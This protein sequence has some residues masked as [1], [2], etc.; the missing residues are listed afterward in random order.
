LWGAGQ[1][2]SEWVCGLWVEHN[3]NRTEEGRHKLMAVTSVLIRGNL[4]GMRPWGL[5]PLTVGVFY[6]L[7]FEVLLSRFHLAKF[8]SSSLGSIHLHSSYPSS[9]NS[10]DQISWGI[11]FLIAWF[12]TWLI[13]CNLKGEFNWS[14][15]DW[16]LCLIRLSL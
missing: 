2:G 11:S 5:V 10:I 6:L 15:F 16:V 14:R 13:A 4:T 3:C 12:I 1:G 8:N 9:I 7:M